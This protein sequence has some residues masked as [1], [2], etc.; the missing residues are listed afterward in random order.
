MDWLDG[1]MAAERLPEAFRAS[2]QAICVP[3]VEHIAALA[4]AKARPVTV[5]LCGSQA[6][7]KSTV[8]AVAARLLAQ[9][10]LRCAVLSLDDL[11]LTRE[12]RQALAAQVHPLLATRGPP[13]TH[14]VTLG[15]A[16]LQS[17]Q[18]PGETRIPRF[19]K[20]RDTRRASAEWEPFDGAADVILFE[21]WCVGAI[22]QRVEALAT[23]INALEAQEDAGGVWRGYINTALAG[24][25]Q[26]LFGRLDT[27]VLL[28]APGF[29]T[30]LA[31]RIEQEAKLRLRAPD[32][33]GVMSDAQIARFIAHYE[34]ITR[35][36][37]NEMPARADLVFRLDERR[38]PIP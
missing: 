24:P 7:G 34:R 28:Q 25:Y 13:G 12:A 2:V 33:P 32:A 36:I 15:E 18:T 8:A 9:Q 19:D 29:E 3:F 38:S 22:A 37:L 21:G 17:L 30:V 14:D 4:A 31:W 1:F 35:H 23:P 20:G 10:G 6:S 27:L 16:T 11:Y 5:G 26:A